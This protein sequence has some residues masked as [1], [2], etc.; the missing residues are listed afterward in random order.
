MFARNGPQ[1]LASI[2]SH[3]RQAEEA[4][5][6]PGDSNNDIFML[7]AHFTTGQVYVDGSSCCGSRFKV[8]VINNK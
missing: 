5:Q 3:Q 1:P 2:E 7:H 8:L 6:F 4:V